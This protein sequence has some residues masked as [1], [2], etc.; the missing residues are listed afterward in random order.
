MGLSPI[1]CSFELRFRNVFRFCALLQVL[2]FNF[3][4]LFGTFLRPFSG[5]DQFFDQFFLSGQLSGPLP[6]VHISFSESLFPLFPCFDCD[7]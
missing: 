3:W 6:F 7:L 2:V 1:W 5:P 4:S